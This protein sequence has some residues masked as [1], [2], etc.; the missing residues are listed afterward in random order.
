MEL[1]KIL[2]QMGDPANG[3]N[4]HGAQLLLRI[5]KLPKI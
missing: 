1:F 5:I 3:F 4:N 2:P